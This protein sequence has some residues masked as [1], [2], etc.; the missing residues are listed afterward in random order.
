MNV[1]P[2]DHGGIVVGW[3]TRVAVVLALGGLLAFDGVAVAVG[4]LDA[5][6]DASSAA[7][8][9]ATAWR[10]Q[11]GVQAAYAAAVAEV[12]DEPAEQVLTSGFSVAPDGTVTLRLRRRISTLVL[13]RVGPL[14]RYAVTIQSGTGRD[15]G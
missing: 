11:G 9:A 5:A 14:K 3:L 15:V 10:E 8:A 4:R 2:R 12:A 13:A 1:R 7:S 6:D